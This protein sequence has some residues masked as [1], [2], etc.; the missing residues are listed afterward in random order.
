MEKALREDHPHVAM[1]L[2]NYAALLRK[3]KPLSSRLPWLEAAKMEARAKAIR[4][5]HAREKVIT[6][7]A[8][9]FGQL[10]IIF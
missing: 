1:S 6:G 9:D 8:F 3:M 2:E 4:A 7:S 5:R 10:A